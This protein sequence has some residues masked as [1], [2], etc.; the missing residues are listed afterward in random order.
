MKNRTLQNSAALLLIEIPFLLLL[1][2]DIKLMAV[3]CGGLL[4]LAFV[5]LLFKRPELGIPFLLTT[6]LFGS[7]SSLPFS[8]KLPSLYFIDIGL[9]LVLFLLIIRTLHLGEPLDFRLSRIEKVLLLYLG[10][11]FISNIHSIDP[12]RGMAYLRYLVFGWIS[13]KM[14]NLLRVDEFQ[15]GKILAYY[16]W[17]GVLLCLMQAV[18]MLT[19]QNFMIAIVTKDIRLFIGNSNYVAAFYVVLIP[20]CFGML[21]RRGL[22]RFRKI[23]YGSILTLLVTCL[24]LTGSRGGV[25]AFVLG[26]L[27]WLLRIKNWRTARNIS[28]SVG[29][30][31]AIIMLNPSTQVVWHGLK[32]M[33]KSASV[34]SRIGTWQESLRI[35][36]DNP[37]FGIGLGNMHYY[38]Q[39]FMVKYTGNFSL[40]KSHNIILELLVESGVIGLAL[41]MA[42]VVMVL[43][44]QIGV[45]RNEKDDSRR[46]LY[47]SVLIANI[48]ALLHAMFEPTILTYLF[49]VFYWILIGLT[50]RKAILPDA[51]GFS[52]AGGSS[53]V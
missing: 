47:G 52:G 41:F 19:R 33:N 49:G 43:K 25:V 40:V 38:V 2:L 50:T 28:L 31:A 13:L 21:L 39:N 20:L 44:E 27:F 1:F 3:F 14:V 12:L 45:I 35:F 17:W 42:V 9:F 6:L 32:T 8:Q 7:L 30:L 16:L 5:W 23:A 36:Q 4:F 24:F 34:L 22:S 11:C 53:S 18:Y 15:T 51:H 37:I 26:S 46:L 10:W 29:V 48:S